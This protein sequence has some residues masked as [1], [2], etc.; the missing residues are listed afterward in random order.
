MDLALSK[1]DAAARIGTSER[2]LDRLIESGKLRAHRVGVRRV[3][4]F[5]SD[6]NAY[7][8]SVET[9]PCGPVVTVR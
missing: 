5:E 7:L 4:I 9:R 3:R 2:T 8:R 1:S 6:L